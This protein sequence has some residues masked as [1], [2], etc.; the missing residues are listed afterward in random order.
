[1]RTLAA[2]LLALAAAR[3]AAAPVAG[4]LVESDDWIN[5]RGA[6]R[7]EEFVGNV[8]YSSGGMKLN[9]DW[10]LFDHG[11]KSWRARGSVVV[12]RKL[13]DGTSFEARGERA[14]HEQSTGR[15]TLEPKA[16]EKVSFLRTPAEGG[17]PDRG[18]AASARW[19]GEKQVTLGGGARVWGPRIEAAADTA[20]YD[21]GTSRLRL[22][23]GRPVLRKVEGEW[24]T[25]L[26]ADEV[27]AVDSPRRVEAR[28]RVKG[29]LQFKDRRGLRELAR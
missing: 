17:E 19:E 5:R 18:E 29:W 28:G 14:T 3:A 8:R 2:L 21:R 26:K 22:T 15:G 6:K 1:M 25:A 20:A 16:G 4:A 13:E 23:G 27:T 7:E 24:T 12:R 9:A 11:A 10:A